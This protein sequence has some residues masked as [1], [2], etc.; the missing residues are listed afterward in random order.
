MKRAPL[1]TLLIL[2]CIEFSN[3][4]NKYNY[5]PPDQLKDGLTVSTLAKE[6]IDSFLVYKCLE[7]LNENP[8]KLHSILVFRNDRLVLEEYFNKY[9]RDKKQ[10]LRSAT[11]SILSLLVGIAIEKGFISGVEEP[12][13]NYLPESL[14]NK[15]LQGE[16]RKIRIQDLLTMRTGLDC[17]DWD[18]KSKGQE[19]KVYKKKDWL[20]YTLNLPMLYA[21]GDTALY[22]SM[23]TVLAAEIVSQA[24]KMPI[25]SF[26]KMYLFDPLGIQLVKWGHTS[27]RKNIITSAK[28]LYL[29]PRDLAKIGLLV[30]NNG[31]YKGRQV[32]SGEWLEVSTA[33]HTKL[34]G[35]EY[36]FLWWR[37]SFLN[38]DKKI[39][40]T[41]A[42]G[43]GGQYIMVFPDLNLVVV[44]TGGAYNSPKGKVPF[45]IVQDILLP[46]L[47]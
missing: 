11:K 29:R 36:G 13:A 33:A 27:S 15:Y 40:V 8:F 18:R 3:A 20:S 47:R 22:C 7:V 45:A 35:L 32:I 1:F 30:A 37:V 14:T 17:N 34:N 42:M 41:M 46:S 12:I 21:P 43:N 2:L 44:F 39:T 9:D 26:A 10:D 23:G 28:R 16:K 38:G 19:D 6:N 5:L 25:D 24:A 31:M 4:Q